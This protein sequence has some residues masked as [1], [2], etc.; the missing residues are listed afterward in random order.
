MNL[1]KFN[2]HPNSNKFSDEQ[3]ARHQFRLS[4]SHIVD[5]LGMQ[6]NASNNLN[7]ESRQKEFG[8]IHKHFS[9]HTNS[10]SNYHNLKG[11][12][13]VNEEGADTK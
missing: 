7:T 5:S 9:F 11:I 6:F 13:N 3:Q 10:W 4:I 8:V 12:Q 1:G 2:I